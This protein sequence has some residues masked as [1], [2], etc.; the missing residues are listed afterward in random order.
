M[1]KILQSKK[2]WE[3]GMRGER[4]EAKRRRCS[5]T[6]PSPYTQLS[7]PSPLS[8]QLKFLWIVITESFSLSQALGQCGRA[9]KWASSELTNKIKQQEE[10]KGEPVSIFSN[11]LIRPLHYPNDKCQRVLK[12]WCRVFCSTDLLDCTCKANDWYKCW[13]NLS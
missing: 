3:P 13:K 5:C 1:L 12:V 8:P 10:R 9:K 11:S 2:G 7:L 4:G 6:S